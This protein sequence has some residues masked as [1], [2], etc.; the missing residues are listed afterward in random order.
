MPYIKQNRRG[1]SPENPGELNFAIT[2]VI[3]KYLGDRP[4]YS[5]F[6]EVIGAL[7]CVKLELYRRKVVPYED[8]KIKENGD[9]Y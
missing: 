3:L 1:K 9:V 4:T 8:I 5:K 2:S 7:E 6:N